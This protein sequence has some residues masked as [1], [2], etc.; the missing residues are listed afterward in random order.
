MKKSIL[1]G[2]AALAAMTFAGPSADAGEVKFGGYYMFRVVNADDNVT[3]EGSNGVGAG[4]DDMNLWSHR[5]QMNV[6]MKASEKSHAHMRVRVIDSQAVSGADVGKRTGVLSDDNN[7]NGTGAGATGNDLDWD[8]RQLWLETEAWGV[9]VKVGEMPLSLNDKILV[10]NDTTSFGTILLSKTFGDVTVVGA[11]VKVQENNIGGAAGYFSA[12]AGANNSGTP[13]GA[14]DD[15]IDLYALSLLGKAMNINYQATVAYL[16]AGSDSDIGNAGV[17]D[18]TRSN[19]DTDNWWLAL[20]LNSQVSG[21]DLTGTI[22]YD[23]GFD[24]AFTYSDFRN[25]RVGSSLIAAQLEESD[26]LLALRASGKTGFGGWNAYG[27][28]AGE[29]FTNI[30]TST[31][32]FSPTWDMSGPHGRDLMNLVYET[33]NNGLSGGTENVWG[34]GAGL[35]INAGGWTIKPHLDYSQTVE[36]N[37]DGSNG[38]GDVADVNIDSAWGGTLILSTPIQQDT[39]L[40]LTGQYVDVDLTNGGKARL[41]AVGNSCED[42]M[43]QLMADIKMTF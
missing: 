3:D 36:E 42:S 8:I 2:A 22:I 41:C 9:G 24:N 28:Y 13:Y 27:F 40:S 38:V 6:D 33:Y 1:L 12:N 14:S 21:I 29:D 20:T 5:L 25:G 18:I 10:N 34:I 23:A 17:V 37:L 11:A 26:F 16:N 35:A 32:E 19:G 7:A 30:S 39:V 31:A 15:D 4:A 43:H